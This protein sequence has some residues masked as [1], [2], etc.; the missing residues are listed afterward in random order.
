MYRHVVFFWLKDKSESSLFTARDKLRSLSGK[1]EGLLSVEVELDAL[2]S[3]RSCDLCLNMLFASAEAL[4]AYRTH[5]AHLPVQKHMHA[6]RSQSFAADYPIFH[7]SHRMPKLYGTLGPACATVPILAKL[8][9]AGL[10]G[11][12]LSLQYRNMKE[13]TAW[14][15]ALHSAGRQ[16]GITPELIIEPKAGDLPENLD[17][18]GVTGVILPLLREAKALETLKKRASHLRLFALIST[19]ADMDALPS[20]CDTADELLLDR[21]LMALH[22][23]IH[24]MPLL[25]L[26]VWQVATAAGKPFGIASDLLSSMR[27]K[28]APTAAEVTDIFCAVQHGVSS[29]MLTNETHIGKYPVAAVDALRK[30]ASSALLS[31]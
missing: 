8:L 1:I 16:V 12:R 21:H 20:L 9:N 23:P 7:P 10:Y 4:S 29:L 2:H 5:P 17:A 27:E 14:I 18:M 11:M 13:C 19:S 31:S 22:T 24:E 15:S 30:A 28:P 3:E 25:Q 26:R 6:V